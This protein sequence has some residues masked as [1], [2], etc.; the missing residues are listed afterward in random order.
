MLRICLDYIFFC[1]KRLLNQVKWRNEISIFDQR[2]TVYQKGYQK[3][4]GLGSSGRH[5]TR[6]Q[7]GEMVRLMVTWVNEFTI[8]FFFFVILNAYY[9][10]PTCCRL[11][12]GSVTLKIFFALQNVCQNHFNDVGSRSAEL[13]VQYA[14][15]DFGSHRRVNSVDPMQCCKSSCNIWL[16][17]DSI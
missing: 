16:P 15:G 12:N 11:W 6:I 14:A 17:V 5:T 7:L 2:L 3:I 1:H 9:E 4:P 13:H 8:S 10:K